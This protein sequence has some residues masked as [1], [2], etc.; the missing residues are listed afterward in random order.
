MMDSLFD[1]GDILACDILFDLYGKTP[2]TWQSGH[3]GKLI[4]YRA[5]CHLKR[6]PRRR[7]SSIPEAD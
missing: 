4:I 1:L 5:Y 2:S 7:L 6:L 3:Q